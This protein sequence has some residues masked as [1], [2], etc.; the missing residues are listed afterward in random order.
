MNQPGAA[1]G[2]LVWL[3]SFPKSGNT[4]LRAILTALETDEQ[5]FDINNLDHGGQPYSVGSALHLLALDPRWLPPDSVH[6]L[7][8]SLMRRQSDKLAHQPQP[9]VFRK[10]HEYYPAGELGDVFFPTAATRAAILIVRDPRDVACSFATHFGVSIDEA[11]TQMT[12]PPARSKTSPAQMRTKQVW[13]DWSGHARSWMDAPFPT[14]VVRYEDLREVGYPLVHR[15]LAQVGLDVTADEVAAAMQL[16]SFDTLKSVESGQ[17]F[18]ERSKHTPAFFNRGTSGYWTEL[19]SPLQVALIEDAHQEMM[20]EFGYQLSLTDRERLRLVD[21]AQSNQRHQTHQWWQLPESF[22]LTVRAESVPDSISNAHHPRPFIQVNESEA[23]VTFTNNSR[24]LVRDGREICVDVPE[25]EQAD[26][27]WM[28]QG[29]GVTL[30]MLQRGYL[31]LHAITMRINGHYVAIAG[32]RGAGKSTTGMALRRRGHRLLT[33]DVAIIHTR[34]DRSYTRPFARNV[35]LLPDSAEAV[36]VDYDRLP[37]LSTTR[38]KVA[39]RAEEPTET[40]V[41]LDLIVVL[42]RSPELTDITVSTLSGSERMRGLLP[43]V[44]RDGVAPII[45]GQEAYFSKTAELAS[46]VPVSRILRPVTGLTI[47]PVC[48][49]IEQLVSNFGEAH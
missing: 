8:R 7:R 1:V 38:T 29:W 25:N 34:N 48:D 32:H 21:T 20:G 13:S 39:F 4:W 12:N 18:R 5:L 42:G 27:S 16:T 6:D 24:V 28:V 14:Q 43:H 17:G 9:L 15:T 3:A 11:I 45:M 19:L 40:E 31:S 2:N 49:A 37:K 35:H 47:D 44:S 26:V 30:S 33:D 36:G 23:L 22:E 41:P 10:T 46:Q